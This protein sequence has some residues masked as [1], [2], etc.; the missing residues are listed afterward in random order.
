MSRLLVGMMAAL[1]LAA[2]GCGGDEENSSG[3]GAAA[4][5]D[6]VNAIC[7]DNQEAVRKVAD[8]VA[9]GGVGD[10]AKAAARVIERTSGV[11]EKLLGR[12][13]DVE[14]P[15]DVRGDYD[16]FLDRI[17]DTL[18]LFQD[19]ADVLREGREDPELTNKLEE[20]AADTRPF[21]TANDLDACLT[22]AA[23]E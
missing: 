14:V 9:G 7:K 1:A 3:G 13:R 16:A 18:P 8:E 22:D 6:E 2:A 11:Q 4:W 5:K 20:V 23:P 15:G 19:L 21:A 12:L 17:G 10:P